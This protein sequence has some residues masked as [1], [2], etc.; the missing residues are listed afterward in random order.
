MD[1]IRR[2]AYDFSL[3]DTLEEFTAAGISNLQAI[4]LWRKIFRLTSMTLEGLLT[5]LHA[6]PGAL[7]IMDAGIA[8]QANIEWLVA[9]GYRYLVV[10]RSRQRQDEVFEGVLNLG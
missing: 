9:Q 7:V 3:I 5:G 4:I 1:D 8:T 2:K 6:P 10:S